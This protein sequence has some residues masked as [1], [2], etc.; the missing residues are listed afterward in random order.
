MVMQ[1]SSKKQFF[2][3]LGQDLVNSLN[4]AFDIGEMSV[5]QRRELS[6]FY[7]KKTQI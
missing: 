5:S 7:P 1:L 4:A 2:S 6:R 3:V